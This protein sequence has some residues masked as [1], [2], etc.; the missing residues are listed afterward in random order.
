MVGEEA[1][2]NTPT[3][4]ALMVRLFMVDDDESLYTP[5]LTLVPS[6]VVMVRLFMAGD[7]EVLN[8]P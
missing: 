3:F 1:V 5:T 4:D 7:E 8:T 2:L 6:D